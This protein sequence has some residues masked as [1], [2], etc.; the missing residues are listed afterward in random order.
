MIYIKHINQKTDYF[1]IHTELLKKS[2]EM[3]NGKPVFTFLHCGLIH[4][5]IVNEVLSK[6]EYDDK[7]YYEQ[8]EQNLAKLDKLF[9]EACSYAKKIKKMVDSMTNSR[10]TI[11]IFL[12]DHGTASGKDLVNVTMVRILTKKRS[13]LFIFLSVKKF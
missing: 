6:Y 9:L 10:D 13:E 3:A 12:S 8:K 11:I 4:D 7:S 2:F 1:S 5:M